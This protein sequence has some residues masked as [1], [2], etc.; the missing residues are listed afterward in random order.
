MSTLLVEVKPLVET[1]FHD[2]YGNFIGGT[3]VPPVSGRYFDN[4]SPVDGRLLC[5]VPR[6]DS[7][8]VEAALDAAHGA[9]DK[10]GAVSAAERANIL[11]RI[12]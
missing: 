10:W 6:S 8:D 9:K 12:A 4:L 2:L 11:N 3:W 7:A 1:P 5:R